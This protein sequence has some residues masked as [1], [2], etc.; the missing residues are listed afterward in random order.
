MSLVTTNTITIPFYS[1]PG[2]GWAKVHKDFLAEL[3]IENQITPYSYERGSF[4]YLEEDCDVSTLFKAAAAKGIGIKWK[5]MPPANNESSIRRLD[6]YR[7]PNGIT[8][9]YQFNAA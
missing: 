1:D 6:R 5:E 3:G 9:Q 4:A 7:C 8:Y 2:H